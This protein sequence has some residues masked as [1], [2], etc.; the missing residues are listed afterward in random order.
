MVP[1]LT[2]RPSIL[3]L[4]PFV[5]FVVLAGDA[6]ATSSSADLALLSSAVSIMAPA[7]AFPTAQ[8][9]HD[10]CERF[11]RV[12]RTIVESASQGLGHR[13]D[14]H[15]SPGALPPAAPVDQWGLQSDTPAISAEY[16]Y[17]MAQHDW[18]SIMIGF[19]AELG[20][21]DSRTLTNIIEPYIANTGW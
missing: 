19:E 7:T 16:G 20:G 17:P 18:D 2:T 4:V 1:R 12:A 6:I 5:S 15:S 21:Y 10:A 13:R 11:G 8:K 9:M 14:C 3:S